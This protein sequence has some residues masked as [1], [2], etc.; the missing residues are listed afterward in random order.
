MPFEKGHPPMGGRPKSIK[1]RVRNWLEENPN[2]FAEVMDVIESMGRGRRHIICPNCKKEI[3]DPISGSLEANIYTA[4]RIKGKPTA[5]IGLDEADR[6]LLS[7][8]T[9]LEFYKLM[10]AHKRDATPLLK[11]GE[12]GQEGANEVTGSA[13]QGE[14]ESV[15]GE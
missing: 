10:D 9:V 14:A 8:H 2:R 11:E 1:T 6:E 13:L 15:T 5:K 12:Y 3:L 4:D 7:A